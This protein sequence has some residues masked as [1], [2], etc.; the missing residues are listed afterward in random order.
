MTSFATLRSLVVEAR[1]VER[2][3][4][5]RVVLPPRHRHLL[6][7]SSRKLA[8]SC[9]ACTL[10]FPGRSGQKYKL[11]PR[12]TRFLRD[13][14]LTDGQWDSLLIPIGLAFFYRSSAEGRVLAYYP[15]P[16]GPTE[17]MLALEAWD[18][19][20]AGCPEVAA[21]EPDVETLLVNRLAQPAEY[22]LAPIDQCYEL[23][24][25]I[26]KNWHG[27]SGGTALWDRIREFFVGLKE[28]A[29]A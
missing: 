21:M 5:C 28:S 29:G 11:V 13:F 24:G 17:S 26:R 4:L 6:N 23:S 14:E 18:E 16:A 9:D 7:L 25:L 19:I 3:D 22:Y 20:A 15:S 1:P 10:L 8:C 2:C 12:D 27:L